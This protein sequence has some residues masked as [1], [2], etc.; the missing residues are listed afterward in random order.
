MNAPDNQHL[1]PPLDRVRRIAA[2][3]AIAGAVLCL[4]A[5]LVNPA[6]FFQS[7]LVG[8]MFWV[9]I[10][11]ACLAVIM[12]HHLVGGLWG[13][14]IR[15]PAEAGALT[16]PLMALLFLPIVL[17]MR[18]LYPWTDPSVLAAH[19]VVR[20]KVQYLNTDFFLIRALI[21]F[22][23]WTA[24]ALILNWGSRVQDR[25]EDP[26]PT[27]RLQTLSGP[28]MVL[29]FLTVTFAAVDWG[30]S[31]EPEWFSSVYGVMLLVGHVL[32]TLALFTIVATWF[33]ETKPLAE[34]ATPQAFNDL[35]N[36]L[37]AFVM[38]WAY[39]SF[40]Q[41]LITWSGNLAEEIPWYL[42]RSV[43]GWR[44]IAA[45][46]IVFHFFVPF[47]LLLSQ[48][49]KRKARALTKVCIAILFMRFVD[50][51]WLYL[52]AFQARSILEFW[53]VVPAFAAIGGTWM[54]VFLNRLEARSLLPRNNPQLT[55]AL[56]H[57]GHGD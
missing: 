13:F 38:L 11:V 23:I 1:H 8:F 35:G 37:L 32:A 18:Y 25:V 26:Y 3:L 51:T 5:W 34:V 12:V 40:S 10:S 17:G 14:T 4:L 33:S 22:V 16:V 31:L 29:Y 56:E 44:P 24:L 46:L 15:R 57:H 9:G 28:G 50:N 47:F 7:Y 41:Y 42:R 27:H 54:V 45:I 43:G 52:P 2:R 30:M 49:R 39:M 6:R 36:L 19:P 53:S 21:Y 55:A 20:A 48:D